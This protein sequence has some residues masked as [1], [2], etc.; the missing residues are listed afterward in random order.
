M[1]VLGLDFADD[2]EQR[3]LV[4][5]FSALESGIILLTEDGRIDWVNEWIEARLTL[6]APL[7]G[8]R[9]DAVFPGILLPYPECAD[10]SHSEPARLSA[11]IVAYPSADV[12]T[13]WLELLV[14]RLKDGGGDRV[15][16]LVQVKDVTEHKRSEDLLNDEISRRR[17]LVEQSRDGIVVLD[18]GGKVRE[19]NQR[20]ALMLGYSMEEMGSLSVGDWEAVVPEESLQEMITSVGT[21]GDH[22]ETRH[23]RKDG[24]EYEVEI[25]TNGAMYGGKKYI[26]CVCRDITERKQAERERESLIRELQGAAAEIK[27]LR[28]LVPVCC[29]CNKIRDDKGSWENVDV[30]IARHSAVGVTHGICP[31][32]MSKQFP[33][34][35]GDDE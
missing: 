5:M 9:C 10:G 32:C 2:E 27:A 24:S 17:I 6:Q 16:D 30:Y 21:A 22:F 31:E 14:T 35:C 33:Q 3:L 28:G 19:A 15:R 13:S 4:S 8:K 12:P 25:S 23:R 34:L 29:Y 11:Q 1:S 7:V 20:F 18:E 26:F